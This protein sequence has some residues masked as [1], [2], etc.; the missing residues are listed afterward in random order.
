MDEIE[1]LIRDCARSGATLGSIRSVERALGRLLPDDYREFLLRSD[2]VE[3]FLGAG[4]YISLRSTA[5]LAALNE[6]YL[7]NEALPGV[8]I[9]GTNGGGTFYGFRGESAVEYVSFP[10]IIEAEYV[11]L[12]ASSFAGLLDHISSE[13]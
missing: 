13:R 1:A 5:E 8:T 7:V 4:G 12:L 11:E 10:V 6:A 3:G 2:G 9:I